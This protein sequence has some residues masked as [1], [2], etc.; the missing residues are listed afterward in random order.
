L[1]R[2]RPAKR[3]FRTESE[4]NSLACRLSGGGCSQP[5]TRLPAKIP[6]NRE[7]YREFF[8][9]ERLNHVYPLV[10]TGV[11]RFRPEIGTGNEQVNNRRHNREKASRN[12]KLITAPSHLAA[13]HTALLI[14]PRSDYKSR[15]G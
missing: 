4:N 13:S 15:P 1:T 12:R 9:S 14:S 11:N 2:E 7:K 10:K 5:R 3:A 8:P 6:V